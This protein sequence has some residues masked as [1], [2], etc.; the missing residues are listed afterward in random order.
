[1]KNYSRLLI[2]V[3]FSSVAFASQAN[4]SVTIY[5]APLRPAESWIQSELKIAKSKIAQNISPA[6]TATGVVIASPQKANPDYFRHWI[7]D[8][9]LT[10]QVVLDLSLHAK[11][12]AEKNSW[13]KLLRDFT[14][15]SRQN[16][17]TKS[18]A[19]LGE[20]IF[21]V[22]GRVFQGP[23]GRPQNDGPAQRATVLAQWA[24]ILLDRG[25]DD[26]VR[27]WLYSADLPA[28]TVVKAD[29]EYV[30][31]HWQD[32]SFDLWE[33]V[34]GDHFYTRMVQRKALI[35]GAR[36]ADRLGDHMAAS[37]YRSQAQA[38]E[39]KISQHWNSGKQRIDATHNRVEGADYKYSNLDIA[40]ILA[41]LH[42]A[43][44]SFFSV[45]DPRVHATFEKLLEEFSRIYHINQR[46]P[47]LGTAVGRYPEDLYAGTHFN[48]GNPWVL[49]TMAAAEFCYKK[50]MTSRARDAQ[51]WLERGDEFVQRTQFHSYP[52]GSL[53]EQFDRYTGF[54]TSASDLTWSYSA[55]V[56]A[57]WAREDLLRKL[58]SKNK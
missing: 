39:Q 19:G 42:G 45:A 4:T 30:S 27:T 9:A 15:F 52:D 56:T 21:E 3:L 28:H 20:P 57:A 14:F 18:I 47:D 16:Q 40:V 48:A 31:H 46:Y 13:E 49:A 53:S 10:M 38:L 55:V 44:G 8:A 29:L 43:E 37:W 25:Q 2:A 35:V 51:A 23:W 58:R 34:R 17:L 50:G 1:M 12:K 26:F 33:E 41:V 24:E 11:T 22:D 36:L 54:M 7:R 5:D 6:G 32:S